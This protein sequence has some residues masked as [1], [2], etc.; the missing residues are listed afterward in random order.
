MNGMMK[1]YELKRK[2]SS[3]HSLSLLLSDDDH[4]DDHDDDLIILCDVLHSQFGV[5]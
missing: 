4:D 2:H 5:S 3:I 1:N